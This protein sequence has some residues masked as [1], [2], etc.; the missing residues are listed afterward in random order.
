M[1]HQQQA[2]NQCLKQTAEHNGSQLQEES[3]VSSSCPNM[4]KNKILLLLQEQRM[5]PLNSR[6]IKLHNNETLTFQI[7]D[8]STRL[9]VIW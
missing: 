9:H 3:G 2:A 6:T 1:Y 4:I 5:S 7:L 8:F